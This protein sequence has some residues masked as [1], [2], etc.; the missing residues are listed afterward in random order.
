MKI[1]KHKYKFN[2]QNILCNVLL[3]IINIIA[4]FLPNKSDF[5]PYIGFAIVVVSVVM[6]FRYRNQHNICML[7][8]IIMIISICLSFSVCFN[9]YETAYNWQI[10]LINTEENV[11]NIKNY[12]LYLTVLSLSIGSIK[13][14]NI[15]VNKES[16][17]IIIV[18][19][20]IVVLI[21]AILFGFDRGKI[22]TYSSN[23]NVIYEYALII[24]L[25]TWMYSSK[26]K[27]IR[28]FLVIYGL[29][30]S[31]QGLLYGD[32]SSSFPMIILLFILLYKKKYSI[33]TVTIIALS[34]ILL[35]NLID[36]FRN[37]GNLLSF[38]NVSEILKRGLF[39]N[40]ISYA[41][42]GGTQIIRYKY[43]YP[44][45]VL[46]HFVDF[47]NSIFWGG[48]TQIMLT[49]LANI[50][51]FRNSGGGM[52]NTYFFY[53]GGYIGTIIGAIIVGRIIHY[54]FNSD[55]KSD[56]IFQITITILSFR[57]I[58]YNPTSFFRTA[59]LV[60]IIL[61]IFI[62]LY[63]IFLKNKFVIRK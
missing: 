31:L 25:F 56:Y 38:E 12:L 29:I 58:L 21:Y 45:F 26:M 20:G 3:I 11:I 24:F 50:Y 9:T 41:F 23:T 19:V 4:L 55:K 6:L 62:K 49:S 59:I 54:V 14:K 52:S 27:A 7:I 60:P 16:N 61:I 1:M 33:I 17:N 34:G 13:S 36:I 47:L 35:G 22:G 48:G 51:G 40:T 63:Y 15:I 39:V 44:F 8:G 30:Y 28:L 18:L 46:N 57:W 2:M 5:L 10:Q 42:Y 37:T 53:W 43:S 32:R